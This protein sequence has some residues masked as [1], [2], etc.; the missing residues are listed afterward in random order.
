[1]KELGFV[2]ES[3][4]SRFRIADGAVQ[5]PRAEAVAEEYAARQKAER[6]KLERMAGY[7]QTAMCRWKLLLDYFGEGEGFDRCGTCDNCVDPPELRLAPP[8]DKERAA[9]TPVT[10]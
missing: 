1:M 7:G 9:F 8:I 2:R 6:D 5:L 10:S 3:R 4:G